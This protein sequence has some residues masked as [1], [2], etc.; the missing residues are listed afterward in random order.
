VTATLDAGDVIEA[1]GIPSG[2]AAFVDGD[3]QVASAGGAMI[4]VEDPALGTVVVQVGEADD[5]LVDRAV[6]AS[7][8]AFRGE[9][10]RLRG[11]Q[12]GQVMQRCAAVLREHA[13]EIARIE[14]LDTGKPLSQAR[15]DVE[16]SARYFEFYAG[17]A[18][19]LHG[20]TIPTRADELVYTLREP[21][22]VIAHIT[23]WNS[24]LSQ[25]CR[26][27]APSLA[28]GNTV[29]VKPSEVTPLSTLFA[30][31]LL[32]EKAGLPV[33]T[34]TVVVGRGPTTGSAVA[35]HLGVEHIAFTGS[36]PT[37]TAIM[38]MAAQRMV[39]CNLELGGKSP[40]IVLP[41]ADLDKAARAGA[42][43]T[44]RNSGQSCFATTRM[45]VHD[46]V[47]DEFIER[48]VS[49]MQ[50]LSLGHGLSDPDLGPLSSGA[51]LDRVRTMV[52]RAVAD[53]A[54][55]AAGGPG[56]TL[57]L[58][59]DLAGG[60]FFAP[61]LLAD[62]DNSSFI[63]QNEVF[64]PVQTVIRFST[65][66]EAVALANDSRYGLAAGVFT[67]DLSAA[68]T[69]ASR[70]EAGQIQVNR[71]P[72]GD[73]QTPFGGYKASGIGREKGTEALHHYS[74]LKTVIIDLPAP[75]LDGGS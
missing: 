29:I 42:A 21:Y 58:D 9:W 12:R 65:I 28:C 49:H 43:A 74:Q 36:V 20:E 35:R 27:V 64:G 22:G 68:H 53:G 57:K 50:Q 75:E 2:C 55:L 73:V 19:K 45:I 18:D 62:V 46:S 14:S 13:D 32:T 72:A 67:R 63:A 56:A 7:Q 15:G 1:A 54:R 4:D 52:D 70:L 25:M 41:D 39:G 30:V 8:A 16:T 61:T 51:Q 31:R 3:Y 33:N 60:H 48:C 5:E 23:P 69:L 47:Y 24:P 17:S 37:G 11:F 34:I 40:T 26:G 44:I 10:S 71:Y 6:R 38:T 59:G 66:D